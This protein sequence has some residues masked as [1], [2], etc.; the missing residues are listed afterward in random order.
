GGEVALGRR[1]E[2]LKFD[3]L[4]RSWT[5]T[6]LRDDGAHEVRTADHVVSTA[7]LRELMTM[8]RPAPISLFH[9][10]E[11]MYRDQVTVALVGRTRKPLS[12]AAIDVHDTDLQVGRVQNYRAWSPAMAPEGEAASC[13][14]L[15]Y[16]CF[17]GDGLWTASD[18][19]LVALAWREAAVMGLMDPT[20]VRDA[21]VVRQRK[22]LPIEDEDCAEHRA[23]IRLDLKM[24]FP[25]LHLAG[26]NGL[27]RD[28]AR[29]QAT[30]SGLMTA[31][32]ILA[33]ETAHDVWE[34]AAPL[35]TGRRA[36]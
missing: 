27:H 9:A 22:V 17:E 26:R 11:L 15:D 20:A 7:P 35:A 8:L 1:V 12:E 6:I 36:A 29:D 28:G 2:A 16:F 10:G 21:R 5:V 30:L 33:G 19:D 25:S 34:V 23:M 24:Q 3:P 32:N 4:A 18:A 13:L 14:G 31:E